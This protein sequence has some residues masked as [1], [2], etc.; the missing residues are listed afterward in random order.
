MRISPGARPKQRFSLTPIIDVVFL[1]LLFF[2]LASTFSRFSHVE[3]ALGGKAAKP[4]DSDAPMILL[5]V[6]DAGR[7]SVNGEA[8]DLDGIGEALVRAA[9]SGK[10]RIVIKPSKESLSD[11]IVH[12]VEHSQ[13]VRL[14]PVILVR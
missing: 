10:A 3:V 5:A 11:D 13:A 1:L 8:V 2:M 9:P 12:A 4:A 14:G 6:K 7:F